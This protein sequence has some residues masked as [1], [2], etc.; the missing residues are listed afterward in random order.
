MSSIS[1]NGEVISHPKPGK[2][3]RKK[4]KRPTGPP[5]L[6]I[7][8]GVEEYLNK[9]GVR[10]IHIPDCVYRM[11]APHSKTPIWVKKEISHYLKGVPDLMIFEDRKCLILE[12]KRKNGRLRQP[13]K[14][15]L[16]GIDHHVPDSIDEAVW[17][18]NN[19]RNSA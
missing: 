8:S 13:Q 9:L 3:K 18:I 15:W 17:V 12:I 6:T 10:Y 5:E 11:C 4:P 7:Q 16:K 19:W 1:E 2:R 14:N